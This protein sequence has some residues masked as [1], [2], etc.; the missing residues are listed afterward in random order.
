MIVMVWLGTH[1]E[2]LHCLYTPVL[3]PRHQ[4]QERRIARKR[5]RKR[6]RKRRRRRRWIL[7]SGVKRSYGREWP[8]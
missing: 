5:K 8:R 7:K 2:H 6:K 3:L 4:H 1:R